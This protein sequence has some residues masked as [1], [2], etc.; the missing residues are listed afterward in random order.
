ML[1]IAGANEKG[2][3][4][5]DVLASVNT[6]GHVV[7]FKTNFSDPPTKHSLHWPIGILGRNSHWKMPGK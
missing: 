6:S 5:C 3:D 4:P 7:G 2:Y 1:S